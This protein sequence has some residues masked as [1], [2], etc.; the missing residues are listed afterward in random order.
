MYE[1]EIKNI[2][3]N[4]YAFEKWQRLIDFVFPK[5]NFENAIVSLD[6]NSN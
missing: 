6:D 5:V 4:D 2:L 3:T 1:R